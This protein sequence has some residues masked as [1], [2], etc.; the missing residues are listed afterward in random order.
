MKQKNIKFV[1]RFTKNFIPNWLP[2]LP[3]YEGFLSRLNSLSKLFSELT[4]FILKN[5]K[6]KIN[7][8]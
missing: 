7:A 5:N 2:R 1:F 3:S 6:F 8:S 4:H